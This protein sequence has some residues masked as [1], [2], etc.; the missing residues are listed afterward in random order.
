MIYSKLFYNRIK[1]NYK[2]N[3]L[4]KLS[5]K[6]IHEE[7]YLKIETEISKIKKIGLNTDGFNQERKVKV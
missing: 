6:Y 2:I 4:K 7:F 5:L 1:P 3:F